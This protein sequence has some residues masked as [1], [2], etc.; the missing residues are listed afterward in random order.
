MLLGLKNL[1]KG[2]LWSEKHLQSMCVSAL[3]LLNRNSAKVL[4]HLL[5]RFNFDENC[6]FKHF[7]KVAQ[8]KSC[9]QKTISRNS[10]NQVGKLRL[11]CKMEVSH[12]QGS[13]KI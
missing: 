12:F 10:T 5:L 2:P 7:P 6:L 8:N 11:V 1:L 4:T 9:I 3:T 13:L